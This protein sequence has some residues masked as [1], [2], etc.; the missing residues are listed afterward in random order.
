MAVPIVPVLCGDAALQ[1]LDDLA[2]DREAKS[3]VLAELFPRRALGVKPVEDMLELGGRDPRPLILYG[4][5][6]EWGRL[7]GAQH[8]MA[9]AGGKAA[10]IADQVPQHLHQAPFH[11]RDNQRLCPANRV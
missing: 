3:R 9:I 10:R 2:A 8:D 11:G 1:S 5:F 7:T 4:N 6:H